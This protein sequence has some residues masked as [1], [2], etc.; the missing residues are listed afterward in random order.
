M[1][2]KKLHVTILKINAALMLL[3]L[4]LLWINQLKIYIKNS[5]VH[6]KH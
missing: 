5:T 2:N 4:D 3:K 1:I 6:S